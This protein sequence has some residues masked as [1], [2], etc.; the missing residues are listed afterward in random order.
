MT[1]RGIL[2]CGGSGTRLAPLTTAVPKSLLPVAN[3]PMVYYPLTTL[4]LAGIRELLVITTPQDEQSFRR[5]LKDGSQWGIS[6]DYAT[7]E[8]PGGIAQ[9]W[10]VG[11][12]WLEG[13]P[14]CLAL[15]DNV[16][17]GAG[18]GE[19][20][21]NASANTGATSLAFHVSDPQRYG[22]VELDA[23]GNP[24]SINEKPK[25]PLSNWAIPG[26]YFVD[27]QA[28][29]IASSLKPSA[30]G[31]VE[32]T[33]V[34]CHYLWQS[35]L[36]IERLGRGFAWL[37]AGTPESLLDASNFISVVEARCGL[38][39][40]N[41]ASVAEDNGWLEVAMAGLRA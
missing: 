38:S 3:K 1:R 31:E 6:I 24:V 15:G 12:Q 19:L 18:L 2:L 23:E 7:Q 40:G 21:R 26:L 35:K 10:I 30:R 32:V 5:L 20:L 36:S 9:A 25:V 17:Y 39:I 34:L 41:P 4:M 11:E 29:E 37:D 27:E 8:R 13:H 33:D 28:P 22:V 16:L 14:S